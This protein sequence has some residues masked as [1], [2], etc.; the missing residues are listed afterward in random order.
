MSIADP[1]Q[2][3]PDK[4]SQILIWSRITLLPE[5]VHYDFTKQNT[6]VS[7]FQLFFYSNF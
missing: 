2:V 6:F 4:L 1:V 5:M 3:V 7:G